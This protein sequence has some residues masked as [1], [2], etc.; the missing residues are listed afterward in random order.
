MSQAVGSTLLTQRVAT[1]ADKEGVGPHELEALLAD[2]RLL[3]ARNVC[4]EVG[5]QQLQ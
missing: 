1:D 5:L 4:V 3:L 2:E